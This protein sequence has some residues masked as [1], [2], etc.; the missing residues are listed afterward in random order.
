MYGASTDRTSAV[1]EHDSCI[2][3]EKCQT[4]IEPDKMGLRRSKAPATVVGAIQKFICLL[5]GGCLSVSSHHDT[6]LKVKRDITQSSELQQNKNKHNRL[7]RL[8]L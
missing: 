3:D 7:D 6:Q 8:L 4:V 5:K 2:S 1:P